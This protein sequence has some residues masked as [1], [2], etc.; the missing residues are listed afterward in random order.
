MIVVDE[1]PEALEEY[2]F[3]GSV[4][5]LI[6]S[7]SVISDENSEVFESMSVIFPE[8]RT[9]VFPVSVLVRNAQ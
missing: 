9:N 3:S 7:A 1:D 5:S 6:R 8:L 2:C 4:P